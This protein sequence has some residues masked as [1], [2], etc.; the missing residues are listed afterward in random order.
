MRVASMSQKPEVSPKPKNLMNKFHANSLS[1]NGSGGSGGFGFSS[2]IPTSNSNNSLG[3]GGGG[4]GNGASNGARPG[5]PS[6][7][8]LRENFQFTAKF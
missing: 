6:V 5:K 7:Q 2:R 4:S 3:N 1:G 8:Q